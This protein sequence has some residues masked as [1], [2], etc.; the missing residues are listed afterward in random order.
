MIQNFLFMRL[1]DSSMVYAP[2]FEQFFQD[3]HIMQIQIFKKWLK[4]CNRFSLYYH[5][6]IYI[7]TYIRVYI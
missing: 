1:K 3:S 4:N 7:Y 6:Y 5:S 2:G